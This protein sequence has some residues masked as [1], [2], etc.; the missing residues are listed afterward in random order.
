MIYNHTLHL[1][2]YLETPSI[3]PKMR[4]SNQCWNEKHSHHMQQITTNKPSVIII[5]DSIICGFKR[6]QYVWNNYFGKEASNCRIRGDKVENMLY[7]KN[8]SS[9]PHHTNTVIVI[10]GTNNLDRDKP[11]DIT[12]GLI[13]AVVFLQLKH[14]KSKIVISGIL[15]RNKAKSLRRK[16][17][18]ETKN[19][20]RYEY[21]HIPNVM[22]LEPESSWVKQDSELTMELFYKDELHPIEKGYKKL[23]DSISEILRDPKKGFHHYPNITYDQPVVKTNTY[24]LLLP[25][26]STLSTITV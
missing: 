22:Y 10:C 25:T 1:H 8:Q 2:D 6:Y 18:I 19:M 23:A 14:K 12:N 15:P 11:S 7:R 5:G 17:L 20:L 21:S 4:L 26:K 24:F 3:T 9:I 16:K 13:C